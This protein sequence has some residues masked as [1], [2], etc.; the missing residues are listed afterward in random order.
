MGGNI[1]GVHMVKTINFQLHFKYV[2][3]ID[4]G[5]FKGGAFQIQ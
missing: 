3:G 2:N 5:F 4:D 1:I